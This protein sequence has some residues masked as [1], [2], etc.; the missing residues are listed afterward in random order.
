MAQN[1]SVWNSTDFM[2]EPM[3]SSEILMANDDK[4]MSERPMSIS[5][6]E[7]TDVG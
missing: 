5:A 3:S 6:D 1:H 4:L 2:G 7:L